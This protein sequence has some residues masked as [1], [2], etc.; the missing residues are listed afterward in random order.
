MIACYLW[1]AARDLILGDTPLSI[2]PASEF[3][4]AMDERLNNFVV[5]TNYTVLDVI[6]EGA[7]GI[8][9]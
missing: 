2:I 6:G 9:V 8:V 5:G 4:C 1:R 3:V 7:Y